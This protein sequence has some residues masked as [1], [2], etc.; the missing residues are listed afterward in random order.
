R[1]NSAL[2]IPRTT[3]RLFSRSEKLRVVEA[4]DRCTKPDTRPVNWGC[5]FDARV[6]FRRTWPTG[7]D[8]VCE[9]TQRFLPKIS[10]QLMAR[11]VMRSNGLNA[12]MRARGKVDGVLHHSDRGC[13]YASG[14]YRDRL[15][16]LGMRVSMSRAGD[17]WDNAIAESFFSARSK[18]NCFAGTSFTV[19]RRP[20]WPSANTSTTFSTHN[21]GTQP[22]DMSAQ[23]S[24]NFAGNPAN[25]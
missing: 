7:V 17:C 25:L 18:R 22:S 24:T 13:A 21:G 1:L 5:C 9:F 3:C 15:D 10:R 14:Q 2:N 20:S 4:A 19:T 6:L 12:R 16:A 23:L 11:F 8:G